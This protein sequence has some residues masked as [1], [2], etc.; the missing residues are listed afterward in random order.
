M[1]GPYYV[2]SKVDDVD[3]IEAADLEAIETG[4]ENVDT[5]KAN[6]VA[7]GTTGDLAA[8]DASGDL[9]DSGKTPPDGDIVGTTDT[10][11]LTNKTLTSPTINGGTLSAPSL[12]GCPVEEI[13]AITGTTPAIDPGNGTIQTWALSGNSTPTDSL[14]NGESVLLL[15]SNPGD[16]SVVWTSLVDVWLGGAAPLSVESTGVEAFELF[17][18]GGTVYAA[19]IGNYS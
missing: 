14:A 2:N 10:Q 4:F 15:I 13:F 19:Y 8:L 3:Y 18:A 1:A 7:P 5:D 9:T 6:K 12:D 16:H 11:T 17:K